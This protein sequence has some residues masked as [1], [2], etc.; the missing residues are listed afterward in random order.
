MTR[1]DSLIKALS[2]VGLYD[3]SEGTLVRCELEVYSEA[4]EE[5]RTELETMLRECFLSTAE[6]YGLSRRERIWG[7]VRD[8]LPEDM[9]RQMLI[10]R[11]SFGFDDFTPEGVGKVLGFLGVKGEIYEYPSLSRMVV[12]LRN[13][14][15]TQGERSFIL[16]QIKAVLPAHLEIDTVFSGLTWETCDNKALSFSQIEGKNYT[17]AQ[18]DLLSI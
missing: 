18:I 2:S 17:W 6:T 12:D 13:E 15:F 1:T 10:L 8:D 14:S 9:R 3:L 11:K 4:L 16:S 5:L 7:K